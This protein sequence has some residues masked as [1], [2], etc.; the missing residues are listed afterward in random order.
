MA[1]RKYP[2]VKM[3]EKVSFIEVQL[4]A[5]AQGMGEYGAPVWRI[6]DSGEEVTVQAPCGDVSTF[7]N[8]AELRMLAQAILDNTK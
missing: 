4:R 2:V 8:M 1:K 5:K 3:G 6:E 7:S